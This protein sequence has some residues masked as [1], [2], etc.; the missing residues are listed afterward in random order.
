MDARC[1]L[2]LIVFPLYPFPSKQTSQPSP[3]GQS[4]C[5][6]EQS[7]ISN[8]SNNGIELNLTRRGSVGDLS[9][10]DETPIMDSTISTATTALGLQA[11]RNMT[12]TKWM[13]QVKLERLKQINGVLPRLNPMP[14]SKAS[15]LPP[16]IGNGEILPSYFCVHL[17]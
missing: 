1:V 4:T 16:L 10:I 8:Y 12:E 2:F 14:P 17:P 6:S 9:V 13:E 3:G 7:P 5:S 11:R 15:T